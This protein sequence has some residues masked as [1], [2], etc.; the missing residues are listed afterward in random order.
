MK[1]RE[2]SLTA[3][4][5]TVLCLVSDPSPGG[6]AGVEGEVAAHGV[7]TVQVLGSGNYSRVLQV[8]TS[9]AGA[10]K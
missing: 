6:V 2:G 9:S 4:L 8:G 7:L 10:R 1:L 3:L 5:N